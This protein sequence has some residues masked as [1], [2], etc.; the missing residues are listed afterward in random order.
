MFFA[1]LILICLSISTIWRSSKPKGK[2]EQATGVVSY[3]DTSYGRLPSRHHGAFRYL[4]ISSYPYPFEIYQLNSE[5]T[6]CTLDDLK[7]GDTVDVYFYETDHTHETHVNRFAQ[8]VDKG[9]QPHFIR[10]SFQL[11]LGYVMLGLAWLLTF[12]VFWMR[13][14]GKLPW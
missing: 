10:D 9:E 4:I 5:P 7:V 14:Q 12:L 3:L 11:Y 1:L 13:K 2:Y 6:E 8:F